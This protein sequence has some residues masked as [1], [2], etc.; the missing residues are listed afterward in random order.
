MT[1]CSIPKFCERFEIE[2]G[3][4]DVKS[5]RILHRTVKERNKCLYIHKIHYCVLW[6]KNRKDSLLRGVEEI[7]RTFKYNK[8]KI[9][10][11]SLSQRIR[12]RFP[13]HET[14]DQL[15]IDFVFDLEIYSDQEFA[16]AYAA[17]LDDVNRLRDR[18]VRFLFRFETETEEYHIVF[19]DSNGSP[20]MNVL[21]KFSENYK[22]D[23]RTFFDK[24]GGEIVSLR[25]C[26]RIMLVHLIV[27]LYWIL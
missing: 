10:E 6:K 9:N 1:R 13:N 18:W 17:A 24:D 25:Y 27:G 5:K 15:E 3:I 14:K 2:V 26:L 23:Q 4:H 8:N 12:Y 22:G 19:D 11:N 7:K 20:V 21:K 16:E